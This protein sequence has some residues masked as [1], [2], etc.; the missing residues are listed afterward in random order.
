MI[1]N[2]FE[3]ECA[4]AG[5]DDHV[6]IYIVDSA[7]KADVEKYISGITGVHFSAFDVRVIGEI[8]KNESGKTLYKE[9]E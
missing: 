3:T 4:C 7:I 6:R 5:E 8:P 1:K 9:L 2:H